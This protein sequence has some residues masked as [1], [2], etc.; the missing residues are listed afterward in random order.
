MLSGT[1]A[2]SVTAKMS[3]SLALLFNPFHPQDATY[4]TGQQS[5]LDEFL[6]NEEGI[7]FRGNELGGRGRR[8]LFFKCPLSAFFFFFHFQ[9]HFTAWNAYAVFVI[10]LDC[11]H[12]ELGLATSSFLSTSTALCSYLSRAPQFLNCHTGTTQT[13]E[14]VRWNYAQHSPEALLVVLRFVNQMPEETR[15]DPALVA[16]KLTYFCTQQTGNR[17]QRLANI[18]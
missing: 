18:L 7:M 15:R 8:F 17:Y 10:Q 4:Y 9:V 1:P 6:F 5:D 13:P 14:V 3:R 16:R 12:I 2:G 11:A